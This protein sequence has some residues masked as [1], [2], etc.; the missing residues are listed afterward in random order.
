M[1]L[2]N[3]LLIAILTTHIVLA[4]DSNFKIMCREYHSDTTL[5]K[6]RALRI[7]YFDNT[8]P[9]EEIINSVKYQSNQKDISLLYFYTHNKKK[10]LKTTNLLIKTSIDFN[11]FVKENIL[12]EIISLSN[13]DT[14]RSQ[15][16]I[17]GTGHYYKRKCFNP[18]K[19]TLKP[20]IHFSSLINIKASH[21]KEQDYSSLDPYLEPELKADHYTKKTETL[22]GEIALSAGLGIG[23][24]TNM[25]PLLKVLQLEKKLLKD[26]A[27]NFKLSTKTIRSLAAL[28]SKNSTHKIT[29]LKNS[30]I[31]KSKVDSIIIRDA[32]AQKDKLR[33]ISFLDIKK[34]IFNRMP[35]FVSKPR[36]TLITRNRSTP[37]AKKNTKTYPHSKTRPD[38]NSNVYEFD[39][40]HLFAFD[41]NWGTALSPLCF[42]QIHSYRNLFST[43][44]DIDFYKSKEIMWDNIFDIRWDAAISFF[45]KHWFLAQAGIT[46][47]PSWIIIPRKPPYTYFLDLNLYIE[48]YMAIKTLISYSNPHTPHESYNFWITPYSKVSEG[49]LFSISIIYN[50]SI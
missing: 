3:I 25:T 18:P 17:H 6:N 14:L 1:K 16:S 31:F 45:P 19:L 34:I 13:L 28:F 37:K 12:N 35:D 24:Q 30:K 26:N 42:F 20:D 46:N 21:L 29:T 38:T 39:Y 41:F 32:A 36:F 5:Y 33:Y 2:I 11:R 40:N 23:Q 49:L 50:F 47:T 22:S 9:N 48:D 15:I 43:D 10:V 44:T 8:F 4:S 7:R 27:I